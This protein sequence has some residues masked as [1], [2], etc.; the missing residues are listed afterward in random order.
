MLNYLTIKKFCKES[1][2]SDSAVNEKIR[3]KKWRQ[4]EVWLKAP[5][6]RTLIIVNGY[7][8]W[9]EMGAELSQH[10]KAASKSHLN[11]EGSDVESE[12]NSSPL[13]LI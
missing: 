13:P 11:I 1:G 4:N 6:G 3:L 9:V 5:D 7:E 8:R 2:Y 12:L 10:Q